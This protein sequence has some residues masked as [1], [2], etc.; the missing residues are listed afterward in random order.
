MNRRPSFTLARTL[1]ALLLFLLLALAACK[2]KGG[3]AAGTGS[4]AGTAGEQGTRGAAAP[5][6]AEDGTATRDAAIP[7]TPEAGA[8]DPAT[9]PATVA[10]VSGSKIT[11]EELARGVQTAQTKMAR[12]GQRVLPNLDT[13]RQVLDELVMDRVLQQ[14]AKAAGIAAS[15]A[16]VEAQL[17]L[18]RSKL[19]TPDAYKQAL[20]ANGVSEERFKD[21]L[22]RGIANQ[23]YVDTKLVP[24]EKVSD[25][26]LRE[27]YDKNRPKFVNPEAV[28][29]RLILVKVDAGA[30]PAERAKA[31]E[32]AEG[33]LKRIKGG[34]DFGQ[35]A[36][37]YS[38]DP[39]S[40]VH[41]GDVGWI[42]RGKTVPAFDKAAF[43]LAKPGDLSP[44]VESEYGFQLLQLIAR[45]AT[46]VLELDQVKGKIRQMLQN[47][48]AFD[49]LRQRIASQREKGKI[50]IYV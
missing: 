9:L 13:Y 41:G 29:L 43:A 31:K 23:R 10:D 28:D 46:S 15:D 33:L 14:E 30:A 19:P 25:E 20:A 24:A 34:E 2:G 26:D 17:A 18:I 12:V 1:L 36:M 4:P 22:A 8:V 6:P 16:E 5:P 40:K 35:L 42:P 32:K 27:Y 47:R 45:R 49:A 37:E 38:D 11:R 39:V 50:K 48:R 7:G 44:V 3:D 21:S